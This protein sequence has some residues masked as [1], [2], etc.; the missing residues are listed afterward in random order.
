MNDSRSKFPRSISL[1]LNSQSPVNS[2]LDSASTSSAINSV[3]SENACAVGISSRISR[4]M[5]LWRINSSMI[6]ARVAGV[7]RPFSLIA[8]RSS[9]SS[10][11]LPACSIALSN[12]ASVYR[13]GGRVALA[14]TFTSLALTDSPSAT[15]TRCPASSLL[16][17]SRP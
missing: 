12:V 11:R 10:T 3:I 6:D 17:W 5:Y 2:G 9:S 8:S 13:A 14:S 15:G 4:T 7:P 16:L 1:S